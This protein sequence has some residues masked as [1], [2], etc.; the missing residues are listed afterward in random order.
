MRLALVV[1]VAAALTSSVH[2]KPL[3]CMERFRVK[4]FVLG[5]WWGP[6]PSEANYRAYQDAGFNVLMTYR[7]RAN[8]D[9]G[10]DYRVPDRE[11]E[12]AEK[13]KL[14]VML[15]TYMKN[16]TPWGGIAPDPPSEHP[17]LHPA[18]LAQLKWLLDRYGKSPALCGILLG[19][20]CGLH[21][22]MVEA[23]SSRDGWFIT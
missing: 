15:D 16:E 2:A 13:L 18:R 3:A 6:D 8:P 5:A 12:L 20:N 21:D 23:C 4:D 10:P 7:N 22:Y 11:F 9:H 17:T 1:L 14:W 19:D